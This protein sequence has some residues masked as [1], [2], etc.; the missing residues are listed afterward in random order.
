MTTSVED[1]DE[2]LTRIYTGIDKLKTMY[3][4]YATTQKQ[5]ALEQLTLL[6]IKYVRSIYEIIF[7]MKTTAFKNGDDATNTLVWKS[8]LTAM[9][10]LL[11]ISKNGTSEDQLEQI[12]DHLAQLAKHLFVDSLDLQTI[13]TAISANNETVSNINSEIEHSNELYTTVVQKLHGHITKDILSVSSH[14]SDFKLQPLTNNDIV[15]TNLQFNTVLLVTGSPLSDFCATVDTM[16]GITDYKITN[17]L[18][19]FKTIMIAYE[20]KLSNKYNPMTIVY[21]NIS[22]AVDIKIK[23]YNSKPP[24]NAYLDALKTAFSKKI[25][26]PVSVKHTKQE[27]DLLL[28]KIIP[29]KTINL[30]D[31]TRLQVLGT[32][33]CTSMS[34][35]KDIEL[36]ISEVERG[37]WVSLD[38]IT[39]M[40]NIVKEYA[41]LCVKTLAT[42]TVN[43]ILIQSYK[44]YI[45]DFHTLFSTILVEETNFFNSFP[46]ITNIMQSI[47]H[48]LS[49]IRSNEQEYQ[50]NLQK[51]QAVLA[52]VDKLKTDNETLKQ[53]LTAVETDAKLFKQKVDSDCVNFKDGLT[54]SYKDKVTQLNIDYQKEL[55]SLQTN[56]VNIKTITNQ[57]IEKS[58][59]LNKAN[60]HITDITNQNNTHLIELNATRGKI[61]ALEGQVKDTVKRLEQEQKTVQMHVA[62]YKTLN[63]KYDD[64]GKKFFE[65]DEH[66]KQIIEDNAKLNQYCD[67]TEI[68]IASYD[69]KINQLN[70][71]ILELTGN[72]RDATYQNNNVSQILQDTKKKYSDAE[73]ALKT[74]RE[75]IEAHKKE[76][77]ALSLLNVKHEGKLAERVIYE[78]ETTQKLTDRQNTIKALEKTIESLRD[79]NAKLEEAH[80][81]LNNDFKIDQNMH[82]L[83]IKQFEKETKDREETVRVLQKRI[84]HLETIEK[85]L[86]AKNTG[87]ENTKL[88]QTDKIKELI[89]AKKDLNTEA[90]VKLTRELS[91]TKN[92]NLELKTQ[93]D[94]TITDLKKQLAAL[95][96]PTHVN[97][98]HIVQI[99]ALEQELGNSQKKL[100]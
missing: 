63:A 45:D 33:L 84:I 35:Y 17:E 20:K 49:N 48:I 51:A 62:E 89:T 36:V 29:G 57:L 43:N 86:L 91:E 99:T 6:A 27:F 25:K 55:M 22:K 53:K 98:P 60:S 40:I 76:I 54:N 11:K 50:V 24:H 100:A 74:H 95:S 8:L 67:K 92:N 77:N 61:A 68:E 52:T 26:L 7:K 90:V 79:N 88:F 96:K 93:Y 75:Q 71:K 19:H 37:V 30:L 41:A 9:C 65:I 13:T 80:I 18:K 58:K 4:K 83:Q 1:V 87:L 82:A 78:K 23:D 3:G 85:D 46:L 72:I 10:T 34:V 38:Q 70:A 94:I 47:N 28:Q 5:K 2:L 14:L 69:T 44:K 97:N 42:D 39:A 21:E 32:S 15:M 12:G 73:A 56:D 31:K 66:N 81:K 16:C 64:L 59:E